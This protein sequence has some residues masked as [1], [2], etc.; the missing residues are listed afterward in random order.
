MANAGETDF[1][2]G[3][4]I[5]LSGLCYSFLYLPLQKNGVSTIVRVKKSRFGAVPFA[6]RLL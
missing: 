6:Y 2:V 5:T 3:D 1:L 4:V